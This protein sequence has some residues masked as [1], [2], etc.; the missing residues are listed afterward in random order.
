MNKVQTQVTEFHKAG[1]HVTNSLPTMVDDKTLSL[2]RRL[3]SEEAE[4]LFE[5]MEAG[6]LILVADAIADLL[7]VVYGT[8]VSFGID[9]Q[10]ISDE[11]HRSNMTKFG[12][13]GEYKETCDNTGKSLKDEGGKTLKPSCYEPPCLEPILAAQA[14][15]EMGEM[16]W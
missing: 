2:R 7:Y 3:I 11:V 16:L 13:P 6:D 8:A 1:G 5:A 15:I 9:M 4:E 14:P 10:P 12:K